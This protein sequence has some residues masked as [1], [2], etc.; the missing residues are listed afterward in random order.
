MKSTVSAV[1]ALLLA[2]GAAVFA[3]QKHQALGESQASLAES[4]AQ[5]QKTQ[6]DLKALSAQVAPLRSRR[7]RSRS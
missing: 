2:A 3:W 6:S 5:L 4:R 1:V 7:S